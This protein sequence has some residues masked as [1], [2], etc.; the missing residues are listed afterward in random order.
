[1]VALPVNWA[2]SD[3]A[4]AARRWLGR[5]RHS[6]GLSRIVQAA[7][8]GMALS[9]AECNAV[10]RLLEDER[11]WVLAGRGTVEDLA[12]QLAGCLP[13]RAHEDALIAARVIAK[14]LLE[15]AAG[16]LEPG[17]FQRVLFARLDRMQAS[18]ASAVD[19][20]ILGVHADLAL[21]F[22]LLDAADMTRHEQVIDRLAGV[23]DRLPPGPAG[24]RDVALYLAVLIWW[25]SADPWPTDRRFGGPVLAPAEIE[26]KLRVNGTGVRDMDADGLALVCHRL[27]VLGGPGSGKTWL[28]RRIARICAQDSLAALAAGASADEV[29]LPLY[30]TC[31]QL[32]AASGDIRQAIVS[33]AL[34]HL[35]DLGSW[36]ASAALRAFFTQRSGPVLIVADS[37]DEARGADARLRQA[38]TLPP[39]WRIVLTSR[40][41]S[42]NGQFDMVR[43]NS[44]RVTG[45]LQP[46]SYPA[47]TGPVITCWFSD[48]PQQGESL[49]AQLADRPDLQQAVT[50]PLILAF[51][52]IIGGSAPLP[53]QRSSLYAMVIRRLLTGRWRDS[54]DRDPDPQACLEALRDWAWAGAAR[55]PVSGTGTW[56]DEVPAPRAARGQADRDAL[57]HIAVPTAPQDLDTGLTP[58]RFI[59]RSIRE[60]LTAEHVALRMTAAEAAGELISH[61]WFDPDWEQAAPAALAM[62]PDRDQV[63]QDLLRRITGTTEPQPDLSDVD[64]CWE[65]RRFLVRVSLDSAQDDW[66]AASAA[67]IGQARADLAAAGD[68]HHLSQPAAD[69]PASNQQIR[70]TLVEQLAGT[71]DDRQ[72]RKLAHALGGV[73]VTAGERAQTR[74][75]LASMIRITGETDYQ[76]RTDY[77][78]VSALAGALASLDPDEGDRV[79]TA[80][81]LLRLL[82]HTPHTA[83]ASGLARALA[84][85]DPGERDRA[86][87]SKTLLDLLASQASHDGQV[88]GSMFLELAH[89]L[90]GLNSGT[91]DLTRARESLL[92]MLSRTSFV[93][94]YGYQGREG[95]EYLVLTVT[96]T[97]LAITAGDWP[98]ARN[99]LAG[100]LASGEN[101]ERLAP[102]L[103][104]ALAG[105]DPDEQDRARARNMLA[106]LLGRETDETLAT[107]LA[108]ALARQS[109]IAGDD[110]GE[111]LDVLAGVFTRQADPLIAAPIAKAL[112]AL[113]R[114]DPDFTGS[115]TVPAGLPANKISTTVALRQ[116]DTLA[117]HDADPHAQALEREAMLWLLAR[118]TWAEPAA[119]RA[120]AL[121]ALN[122]DE[123]D[124]KRARKLL[125]GHLE[126]ERDTLRAGRLTIAL[127]GLAVTP[128]ERGQIRRPL[129]LLGIKTEAAVAAKPSGALTSPGPEDQQDQAGKRSDILRK[130]TRV[131]DDCQLRRA[132]P[133]R[134]AARLAKASD[135]AARL[136]T[137]LAA[138]D[139]GRHDR[140]RAIDLL[141]DLARDYPSRPGM[142]PSLPLAQAVARLAVT[143][144]EQR[145][146][147]DSL[148]RMPSGG[149]DPMFEMILAH[150]AA[151]KDGGKRLAKALARL[152]PNEQE[153]AAER[154]DLLRQMIACEDTEQWPPSADKLPDLAV[155]VAEKTQTRKALIERCARL[156]YGWD[157]DERYEAEQYTKLLLRLN[158]VVTDLQGSHS[159]EIPPSREL[160]TAARRHTTTADWLSALRSL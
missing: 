123:Q 35:P 77:Q 91:E 101:P 96:E 54:T 90:A 29:E 100:L 75:K 27:V 17:L 147:R 6:D 51:C 117:V 15:F 64:R 107:M 86:H 159:W 46:L 137:S 26:R 25:L 81:V 116:P 109:A 145:R 112:A 50:V 80:K 129:E 154:D 149:L 94:T 87:A 99:V 84:R 153:R 36:R 133:H 144:R 74:Q 11:T 40:P 79:R 69:W 152:E 28:A 132:E 142:H 155:T 61:L 146:V 73:A 110:A 120:I 125:L 32:F 126:R 106:G 52:C 131:R 66:S 148:P 98:W 59:H 72:A 76:R 30:T 38:D 68:L 151:A 57:D 93:R 18:Q 58:R 150:L 44:L 143:A 1:M 97:A 114:A 2:A 78:R 31:S 53:A 47:D 24:V 20:A 102:L 157:A 103:A 136:A 92:S 95:S 141:L 115:K 82:A 128:Q 13:A 16:D 119:Q 10:R 124:R 48:H 37:L 108:E 70:D 122:P 89:A 130:L 39:S 9:G 65:L 60:H 139:P 160:F 88:Y 8:S 56:P 135:K 41:A 105:P 21:R 140:A 156:Q 127:A 63:L 113:G 3:L 7:G 5:L 121:A 45:V 67:V 83:G 12:A 158:P 43:K 62:H 19:E 23:L 34:D 55:D 138:L 22:C 118:A 14:G 134:Q 33:S 71:K 49:R 104:R 85:L 4:G 42:W 111:Y